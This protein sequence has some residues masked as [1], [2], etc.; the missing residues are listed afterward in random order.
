MLKQKKKGSATD[1]L[2]FKVHYPSDYHD[3][4]KL[5]KTAKAHHD[6]NRSKRSTTDPSVFENTVK[7]NGVQHV[8]HAMRSIN[9]WIQ[10]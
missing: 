9:N 3:R 7:P 2:L 6:D 5:R 8:T 10:N 1:D 4:N